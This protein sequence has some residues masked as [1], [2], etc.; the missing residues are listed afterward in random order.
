MQL[1]T[2]IEKKRMVI[3]LLVLLL[4]LNPWSINQACHWFAYYQLCVQVGDWATIEHDE[5]YGGTAFFIGPQRGRGYLC[6]CRLS[7]ISWLDNLTTIHLSQCSATDITIDRICEIKTLRSVNLHCPNVLGASML[8]LR[9]LPHLEELHI[10]GSP[11][12]YDHSFTDAFFLEY[13]FDEFKSLH[14]LKL[15]G[16][17]LNSE[18]AEGITANPSLESLSIS[19]CT[20]ED[21]PTESQ[22]QKLLEELPSRTPSLDN[23]VKATALDDR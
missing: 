8:K 4:F 15:I 6:D 19:Y 22:F 18:H 16:L 14:S 10:D 13:G 7:W 17:E 20:F 11:G 2:F 5:K 9:D 12:E 23:F 1:P 21:D 3:V